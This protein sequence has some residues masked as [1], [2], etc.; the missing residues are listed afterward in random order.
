MRCVGVT[1]A[2]CLALACSS[3]HA[4]PADAPPALKDFLG[5]NEGSHT[6]TMLYF[7]GADLWRKGGTV[8]GGLLWSPGGLDRDGFTLKL[9]LASGSYLYQSGLT[10]VRGAHVL[11][12]VLPGYRIK[13]G[14]F[15]IKVFAGLDVQHHWTNPD[16][17]SNDLRGTHVGAR[18]NVDIWWE[19]LPSR[20]MLAATLTGS[21]IG[22][23]YGVR[24]AA[25]WR[26][27]D[28]FWAGPEIETSGDEIYHQY[29]AGAHI[30]SLK[31]GDYEWALGGGY[32]SDNNDRSGFYGRFSLLT[33]R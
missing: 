27:F 33:R 16:D 5:P 32:V 14:D 4:F 30:T 11:G 8:Y 22:N 26:V 12:S 13:R 20:M 28:S 2:S 17:P 6:P 15:E 1:F 18:V 25:G 19:P 24:G 23:G 10:D 29:R 3:L 7:S 31:F 9:L 21:T